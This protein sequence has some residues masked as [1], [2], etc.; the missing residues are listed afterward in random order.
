MDVESKEIMVVDDEAGIRALLSDILSSAGFNV[1]VAKDGEDSLNQMRD[2]RFD[3]LITDVN[4]P[5]IDGIELLKR[6]K[7][8]GRSEK[9]IVMTGRPMERSSLD[10]EVPSVFSLL[11]KPFPVHS[12]LDTVNSALA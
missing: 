5:G 10:K 8:A 3:L 11:H 9:V 4:M 1:T 6:M 7:R 12:F 2:R